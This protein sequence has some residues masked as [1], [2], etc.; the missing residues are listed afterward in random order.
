MKITRLKLVNFIGIKHGT[1]KD[2]IEIEF[3]DKKIVMLNGGNGSGKSTIL[4]QLHPFKDS[5][6]ERKTLILDGKDG[7]KEIDIEHD[8]SKYEIVHHY[9][10]KAQSFIKKDGVEM[11]ENAGVKTFE[12]FIQSEFGLTSDYFKIGK[13]GSNTENF[14]ELTASERKTYI[15]KFLPAIEDYLEKFNIVKE[16]F[17]ISQNDIKTISADLEKLEE[18][19]S[20]KVRIESFETLLKAF[21][22]EIAKLNGETAVLSSDIQNYN[23]E[24]SKIDLPKVILEINSKESKKREIEIFAVSF[25]K[26]YNYEKMNTEDLE[27]L[28]EAK[29]PYVSKLSEEVAV[30]NSQKVSKNAF[31]ISVENEI[32][33]LNYNLNELKANESIDEIKNK[34]KLKNEN[35][36]NLKSQNSDSLFSIVSE[37]QKDISVQLSKFETFKNF[38][39]KYFNNLNQKTI[40]PSKTNIELFMQDDFLKNFDSQS[41]NIRNLIEG[42]QNIFSSQKGIL[43]QKEADYIKF[44]EIY[45]DKNI[46]DEQSYIA[47]EGCPFAQDIF[48]LKKLPETIQV[49]KGNI[50]QLRKDLSEYELKADN[51]NELKNLYKTFESYYEQMNPRTNQIYIYFVNNHGSL[52]SNINGN[53]NNFTKATNDIILA[54]NTFTFNIQ[55]ISKIESEIQNL[56]YKKS[57]SEN[58]ESIKKGILDNIA[59]KQSELNNLKKELQDLINEISTKEKLFAS[60]SEYLADHK[61]HL[62]GRKERASLATMISTLAS[63][64][65]LYNQKKTDVATKTDLFRKGLDELNGFKKRKD[66]TNT[67]LVKAKSTLIKIDDLKAR[68]TALDSDYNTIK[69]LKDALDPNKGVPLYFIKA[70]LEKTKDIANELLELAFGENFE[71]NFITTDKEFFIQVRAGENIKNDIKEASQGEIALTT[72]SISLSLIEQA[73]GK[74]NILALDEIDGPLDTSNRENFISILNTQIDKL[75]IEQVFVISHNDAFDTE[76]MDLILLNGHNTEQK[77]D[78]FMRNKEVIFKL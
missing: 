6:D 61:E 58:N 22:D 54:V 1:G 39:I 69:L 41:T 30:M 4:S 46:D 48:E 57:I 59:E 29:I 27:K 78:E 63:T 5:F 32:K 55:E 24:L 60:E 35:L 45:K 68:K 20:L 34:L 64:R 62:V 16:K 2:E 44:Q 50:E 47:C 9:G 65:D 28:V 49:L 25:L 40:I 8:G 12:A 18:E 26:K 67:E 38:I 37:N 14:I 42:K 36:K 72:I 76:S 7:I 19:T 10:K 23:S 17:R 11:N 53:V 21:D 52:I 70:Y 75:G 15:S 31:I 51:L 13:I 74:Y 33:K 77:G 71:I 3:K 66:D 56:E 73:I 43:A